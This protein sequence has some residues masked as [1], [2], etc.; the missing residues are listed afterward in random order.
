[1]LK[2]SAF[3]ISVPEI[4]DYYV[5]IDKN[6]LGQA[7][8]ATD[9]LDIQRKTKEIQKQM[10]N[11]KNEVEIKVLGANEADAAL[12]QAQVILKASSVNKFVQDYMSLY[13]L[14]E[15]EKIPDLLKN[16]I[17]VDLT[18]N[19]ENIVTAFSTTINEQVVEQVYD[20][21]E[22]TNEPKEKSVTKNNTFA[23]DAT[24][25]N[26]QLNIQFSGLEDDKKVVDIKYVNQDSRDEALK[27]TASKANIVITA[28]EQ[29]LLTIDMDAV[30]QADGYTNVAVNANTQ[31][32]PQQEG[33]EAQ[34][35]TVSVTTSYKTD[36]LEKEIKI[37]MPSFVVQVD[38]MRFDFALEY[39]LA[40]KAFTL[41]EVK[42]VNMQD[43]SEEATTQ[44]S[45]KA[46][47]QLYK[48]LPE[49]LM[50]QF[51]GNK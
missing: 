22:V 51:V 38:D 42:T 12:T 29:T 19:K 3:K 40:S 36:V 14:P 18:I 11:L 49:V 26:D 43:I 6:A 24:Y 8:A 35:H 50:N 30:Y 21:D 41:P 7:G 34:K 13:Q 27:L 31:A 5:N 47:A 33:V 39:S 4:M 45:I 17:V 23:I 37:H 9:S 25:N 32:K 10:E 28:E 48:V 16:D 1:M 2:D 44:L 15:T 20:Y 46:L